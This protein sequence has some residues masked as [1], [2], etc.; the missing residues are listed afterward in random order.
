MGHAPQQSRPIS[1]VMSHLMPLL[2]NTII[3]K[4]FARFLLMQTSRGFLSTQKLMGLCNNY[5]HISNVLI[6]KGSPLQSVVLQK[7]S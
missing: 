6:R 5:Q 3:L 2:L 7:V 4:I 1:R